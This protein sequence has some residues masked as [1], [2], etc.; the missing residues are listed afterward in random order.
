MR[1]FRPL[2]PLA[3]SGL[4]LLACAGWPARAQDML[5]GCQLVGGT[6]QCVPGLTADPQQQISVL[7]Q[8]IGADQKLEGRSSRPLTGSMAWSCPVRRSKEL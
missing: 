8:Q 7:R 5:P 2:T 6:L 3:L 4:A 1:R